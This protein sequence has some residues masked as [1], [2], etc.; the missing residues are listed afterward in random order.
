MK[1]LGLFLAVSCV[2]ATQQEPTTTPAPL[3]DNTLT[4]A[5]LACIAATAV[6]ICTFLVVVRANP[7]WFCLTKVN[8]RADNDAE[9]VYCETERSWTRPNSYVKCPLE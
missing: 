1:Y 7:T 5:V 8:T 9:L 4:W 3:V 6:A 2:S